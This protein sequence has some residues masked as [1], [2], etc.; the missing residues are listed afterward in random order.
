MRHGTSGME[1]TESMITGINHIEIIVRD[2]D[3]YV[4]FLTG[5]GFETLRRTDHHG[6]S[7]EM[8]PPGDGQPV[9]EIHQVSGEEVIG[10]NHIALGIQ[11]AA[12]AHA[13][14]RAD[15]KVRIESGPR[16][17]ESTGRT[18]V[19]IRDPDGWRLQLVENAKR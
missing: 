9:F 11:D 12:A 18:N 1:G 16:Y 15:G 2:L 8:K 3:D 5:L 7:I 6:G 19:D 14:L 13:K 4:D 10:I 17:I